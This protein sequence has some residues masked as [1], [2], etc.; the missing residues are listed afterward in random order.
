MSQRA[1]SVLDKMIMKVDAALSTVAAQH[2]ASRLNPAAVIPEASLNQTD[3]QK[4]ASLMRVNHSGEVCAQA[5]YQGQLVTA[6]TQS[7]RE[8]L[9][10]AGDEEVDHLAW[11]LER[12]QELQSH[13]SYLNVFWYTNSFVIGMLA[14][15]AGDHWSLGFVEETERQVATH[16]EGHLGRL[17]E[18]DAKSRAIVEQMR[19]DEQA[20][21]HAAATAGASELPGW[22]KKLMACQAKVMTTLA[23]WI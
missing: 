3:R 12:I 19:V 8:M 21:G 13:P 14:G 11:T 5:L 23:Y 15:M 4:S 10:Q 7:T 18:A 6:R 9:Q 20:H 17:P 1:Y 16:L 2:N 22:I